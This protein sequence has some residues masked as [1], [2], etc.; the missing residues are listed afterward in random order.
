MTCL[1][2]NY[3]VPVLYVSPDLIMLHVPQFEAEW[4]AADLS[5]KDDDKWRVY[6]RID[7]MWYAYLSDRMRRLSHKFTSN[8]I[9]PAT[10]SAMRNR[11]ALIWCW[12]VCQWGADAVAAAG[13][14]IPA[15]NYR[16]PTPIT[17]EHI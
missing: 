17:P 11:F 10:W 5:Q 4:L 14:V 8:E 15:P 1:V 3:V 13:Q 12:C 9:P 2:P 7:P 6:R 16:A